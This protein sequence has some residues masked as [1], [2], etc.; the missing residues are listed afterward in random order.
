MNTSP[1]ISNITAEADTNAGKVKANYIY[2]DIDNDIEGRTIIK[3]STSKEANGIYRVIDGLEGKTITVPEELN[4]QYIKPII[5]PIDERGA[6]GNVYEAADGVQVT[7]IPELDWSS[8]PSSESHLSQAS[9][10]NTTFGQ[11]AEKTYSYFTRAEDPEIRSTSF[12]LEAKDKESAIQVIHNNKEI[13]NEK[14]NAAGSIT[15]VSGINVIEVNVIAQDGVNNTIY[16]Y[17]IMRKG[18]NNAKLSDIK[19]NGVTIS[20][21]QPDKYEYDYTLDASAASVAIS[22]AVQSDSAKTAITAGKIRTEGKEAVCSVAPGVN[23]IIVSSYPDNSS[24]P[25]YYTIKVR[26]PNSENTNLEEMKFESGVKLDQ[27]YS[28]K[29]TAYTGRTVV[30]KTKLHL[31]AEEKDAQIQLYFSNKYYYSH[32]NEMNQEINFHKGTNELTILVTSSNG[33]NKTYKIEIEANPTVYLSDMNYDKSSYTGWGTIKKDKEAE[34]IPISLVGEDGIAVFEKGMGVHATSE[35]IY[36]LE[37]YEFSM[38]STFVGVDASM[39]GKGAITFEIFA[40][41]KSVFKT[42]EMTSADQMQFAEIS[43]KGVKELKLVADKGA[44]DSNDHADYAD[45]KFTMDLPEAPKPEVWDGINPNGK[46]EEQKIKEIVSEIKAAKENDEVKLDLTKNG[47]KLSSRILEEAKGKNVNLVI[48][49]DFVTWYING[50]SIKNSLKDAETFNLSSRK[51]QN[52]AALQAA[53]VMQLELASIENLPFDAKISL[54]VGK[55]YR[56]KNLFLNSYNKEQKVLEY[57][58]LDQADENGVSTFKVSKG[59]K[60]AIMTSCGNVEN[61]VTEIKGKNKANVLVGK[62]ITLE[63]E[64]YPAK[65]TLDKVVWKSSNT[66][67]AVVNEKGVV[68]PKKAALG[69]TVTITATALDGKGAT[70]TYKVYVG[71]PVTKLSV[72]SNTK[73]LEVG[74]PVKLTYKTTPKKVTNSAVT[75]KVSNTKYAVIKADGTVTAKKAGIGKTITIRATAK[76][77]QGATKTIKLT[78]K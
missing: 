32:N 13:L 44:E 26:I 59:G 64:V 19:V 33:A 6:I 4:G 34:G 50:K 75:W 23:T 56:A 15:L 2:S 42:N 53:N 18:F 45:A 37:G 25:K 55:Q 7:A 49:V 54:N 41:G 73:T 76:D 16:R 70:K 14:A 39:K 77:K 22:A 29:V 9:F 71:T 58:S 72:A 8:M 20:D 5:I 3:W 63:A 66:K 12:T 24:T 67:L 30:S 28:S 65:A 31:K 47:G 74:Q 51:L 60:Y 61:P 69:K 27:I 78:I 1:V 36:N 11:F 46:T 10:T 68:T 21:F 57:V 35:L 40:D 38:F 17:V 62:K 48:Q 43:V 52:D